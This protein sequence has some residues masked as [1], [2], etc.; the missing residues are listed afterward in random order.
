LAVPGASPGD[1]YVTHSAEAASAS[2]AS[3]TAAAPPPALPD[4][5]TEKQSVWHLSTQLNLVAGGKT[6]G[7]IK[8][9]IFSLVPNMTL[10]VDGKQ[11]A[12]AKGHLFSWGSKI[13]VRDADGHAI[14]SIHQEILPSLLGAGA[15]SEYKILDPA[16]K[17]V[18]KS[19]KFQVGS[20]TKFDLTTPDGEA[21]ADAR[22]GFFNLLGDKWTVHTQTPG[23]VDPRILAFIPALKTD[24]KNSSASS[25]LTSG[26][27]NAAAVRRAPR[28][29]GFLGGL[30]GWLGA[31]RRGGSGLFSGRRGGRR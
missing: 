9:K 16:G 28:R 30:V 8:G 29:G 2:S 7:V 12:T 26:A 27:L 31:G 17:L 20:L 15:Y 13:D 19:D 11:V 24:R 23:K 10:E 21:V 4:N 22:R 6:I 3:S 18:A 5:Y 1:L 14:G 25:A